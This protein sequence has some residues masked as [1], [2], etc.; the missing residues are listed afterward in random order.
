MLVDVVELRRGG[1]KR[2]REDVLV[3]QPVRGELMLH[4]I[5]PGTNHWRGRERPLQAGLMRPGSYDWVIPPLDYARVTRIRG[6]S[7]VIAGFQ[8]TGLRKATQIH[9]QTW[10]VRPVTTARLEVAAPAALQ[11]APAPAEGHDRT[12]PTPADG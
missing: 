6:D 1:E 7:L 11:A 2:P 5:R 4:N 9:R 12:V 10:W 8:E 3:A